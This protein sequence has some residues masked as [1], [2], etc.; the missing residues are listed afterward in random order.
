M[1]WLGAGVSAT[2]FGNIFIQ[3]NA[4]L[5][6]SFLKDPI[7]TTSGVFNLVAVPTTGFILYTLAQ[8]DYVDPV[9][10]KK[11]SYID[12]MLNVRPPDRAAASWYVPVPG[13]PPEQGHEFPVDPGLRIFK[14]GSE[15]LTAQALGLFTGELDKPENANLKMAIQALAGRRYT[16]AGEGSQLNSIVNQS[17]MPPVI[18]IVGAISAYSGNKMRSYIDRQPIRE[19]K[20]AG[21]TEAEG[22]NPHREFMGLHES[23]W[24][25]ELIASIGADSARFFYNVMADAVQMKQAGESGGKI[26]RNTVDRYSQKVGDSTKYISGP[27]FDSFQ[28]ISPSTETS[29]IAAKSR[30]D[31]FQ[32]IQEAYQAVTEKGAAAG[33]FIGA[34]KRGYT[35]GLG[36]APVPAV[37]QDMM[38]LAAT[39]SRFYPK[40]SQEFLGAN[41]DL[42]A[43]RGQVANST[44]FSPQQKRALMNGYAEQIIDHN[45]T[46][47]NRLQ[48]IE[49]NLSTY[50]GRDIKLDKIDLNKGIDQF[51]PLPP[52]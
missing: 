27:L 16:G 52:R 8:D 48:L 39:V 32:K 6:G 31:T 50:F 28:A 11:Y 23:A 47:L 41:K 4:K 7:G 38:Q 5:L 49:S 3:S 35:Q 17:V 24:G 51:K 25:E 9:T 45:R 14:L 1:Q 18:P 22:K 33:N 26:A 36:Q 20:Q 43:L 34:P 15:L 2:Q 30:L 12:Y 42:F 46:F 40:L 37:D 13:K 19:N 44:Q 21:F 29:A 10:G